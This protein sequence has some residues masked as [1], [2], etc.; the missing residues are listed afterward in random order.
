MAARSRPPQARKKPRR[1]TREVPRWKRA[2][3][4][5]AA[6]TVQDR[7]WWQRRLAPDPVP[8]VQLR[9]RAADRAARDMTALQRQLLAAQ[10]AGQVPATDL[11]PGQAAVIPLRP[12][13]PAWRFRRHVQPFAWLAGLLAVGAGLHLLQHA[14]WW[15][16][17]GGAAAGTLMWL[18]VVQQH[19]DKTRV[20][21][22]WVRRFV[23]AE[24]AAT[25]VWVPLLAV[26]GARVCLG[27]VLLTG[28]PFLGLWVR[29]YRWRP[30]PVAAAPVA[31]VPSDDLQ[32]WLLLA[33]E[34]HWRATLG[35][36]EQLDGGGRRYPI[37]CDGI[38][39]VIKKILSMPDN[40]AGAYHR[41]VTECYAERDPKGIT[42]RGYLT[43]LGSSTLQAGRAWDGRGMDKVTG[44]VRIGRFADGSPAHA[45]WYT[46]R[47][48]TRHDLV[49]GT[50][51][52]GKSELLNLYVFAAL[53]TGWFVPVILDP[54]EGQS[55]PF[56]R[57]RCLYA[58][59]VGQVERML[60]GLHAGFL[61]R[62]GYLATLRWDDDGIEMPGM[63]FF[64]YEMT[65]L[66][67]PL[68]ILD[69]AH[70]VLKD[71]NK[72][73]RQITG[74]TVEMAR[75]IRKT[76]GKMT[77]ATQIPGL[78]ELGGQQALRDMLRGGN[79]WSGRTANKV[80]GGML[81]LEKDPSEIPRYFADGKETA[82]LGYTSGPENRPDA[83]MRTDR[84]P[85]EAYVDPPS[86]PLLDDRFREVMD[87]AM[88]EAVSPTSTVAPVPADK[89]RPLMLVKTPRAEP[90]PE[91]DADEGPEGQRCVDAVW[92][93][94]AED[95]GEVDRGV[96]ISRCGTLAK[97]WKRPKP[98]TIKAIG[99]A[100]AKLTDG[101]EPGRVVVKV[102]TGVY[103][104]RL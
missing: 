91:P 12:L 72:G 89:P 67:M 19:K 44:L 30:A 29:H 74:Y 32:T 90:E 2:A 21:P 71:G 14:V 88:R 92:K 31:E 26:L 49:S 54:Q 83:P 51:G 61:D 38:K 96:I 8:V 70:M 97:E 50:T 75:L 99:N 22:V 18:A 58:S 78:S 36:A 7:P 81:G 5:P 98:W 35:A 73:Q 68:I 15:G 47:Y 60:R 102:R 37:Q 4:R 25:V 13:K 23:Y 9:G 59:G 3:I 17:L 62:S 101:G 104:A 79:V 33:A 52:S 103:Q 28:A 11:V 64:D 87:A 45:K 10:L 76:G 41:P 27:P 34:Q 86:A 48:G 94:L 42:S 85:R 20:F 40:V 95:G 56:W 66:P 100:C 82:G 69:E 16:L 93:V 39:T 46:P 77:L 43:I 6:S 55:L 24:A 63:P 80:G 57:D 84:V 65:G 1:V 53:Q